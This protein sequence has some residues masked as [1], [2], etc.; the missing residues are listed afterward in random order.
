MATFESVSVAANSAAGNSQPAATMS[1]SAVAGSY[2]VALVVAAGAG[3]PMSIVSGSGQ[4]WQF[5]AAFP[6]G[7]VT[8]VAVF[9]KQVAAGDI[10]AA[11]TVTSSG[12][13]H[14]DMA[15]LTY[16]GCDGV[17]QAAGV[18]QTAA[19]TTVGP[20]GVIPSFDSQTI[21]SIAGMSN[22]TATS[23]IS[24]PSTS[25]T[26]RY[27]DGNTASVFKELFV[28]DRTLGAGTSLVTETPSNLTC[29]QSVTGVKVTLALLNTGQRKGTVRT[30]VSGWWVLRHRQQPY[31]P[32]P[33]VQTAFT[34]TLTAQAASTGG[35]LAGVTATLPT[36][37]STIATVATAA[38]V[39]SRAAATSTARRLAA[40]AVTRKATSSSTA[41]LAAAVTATRVAVVTG[42]ASVSYAITGTVRAAVASTG[43]LLA[44][45]SVTRRANASSTATRTAAVAATV[46]ASAVSTGRLQGAVAA[47]RLATVASHLSILNQLVVVQTARATA[48]AT[49]RLA[50]RVTA[51][52]LATVTS[53]PRVKAAVA[54]TVRAASVT[55]ASVSAGIGHRMRALVAALGSLS[56]F[57]PPFVQDMVLTAVPADPPWQ[58]RPAGPAWNQPT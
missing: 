16:S 14:W 2:A 6:Q 44:A 36:A 47:T 23:T 17:D 54:A 38:G 35:R 32:Q 28:Q 34:Q 4:P 52:R 30:P 58:G 19:S 49:A 50:N 10:N 43:R 42:A 11:V 55:T 22:S 12:N 1:A 24:T 7:A 51:T 29:S 8:W 18:A 15:V 33:F 53:S 57:S 56:N 25:Y 27:D 26:S 46:R 9:G 5:V 3:Q 37:A 13:A 48:V 45:V 39:T 41:R 20:A 40:V 21:V 31:P